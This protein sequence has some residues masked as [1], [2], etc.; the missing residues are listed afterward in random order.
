M[1]TVHKDYVQFSSE[2]GKQERKKEGRKILRLDT[3]LVSADAVRAI[4]IG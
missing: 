1:S 3:N 2:K 4:A